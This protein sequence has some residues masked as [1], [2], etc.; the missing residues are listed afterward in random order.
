MIENIKS[1]TITPI[2]GTIL[3]F[4]GESLSYLL[5]LSLSLLNRR[6]ERMFSRSYL[7]TC[8][9]L[10]R[11][12]L[13]S[14]T[15]LLL[16]LLT[17]PWRSWSWHS[18]SRSSCK[19]DPSRGEYAVVLVV[20]VYRDQL[21]FGSSYMNEPRLRGRDALILVDWLGGKQASSWET[22]SIRQACGT[23]KAQPLATLVSMAFTQCNST[24]H[25]VRT[26]HIESNASMYNM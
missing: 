11:Q 6:S 7:M 19:I 21:D 23:A 20:V 25:L 9:P 10:P 26:S 5:S 22:D 17:L 8:S 1:S 24:C 3:S 18:P 2:S 15:L 12:Q 4:R 13:T 14:R 16:A